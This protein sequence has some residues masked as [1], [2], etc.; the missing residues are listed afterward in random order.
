VAKK[1][2]SFKFFGLF[3]VPNRK[4]QG[5]EKLLALLANVYLIY[6]LLP[7]PLAVLNY[8]SM[9]FEQFFERL[10]GSLIAVYLMVVFILFAVTPFLKTVL[11]N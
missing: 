8:S 3:V 5:G 10:L 2:K 1:K 9:N 6:K 4:L 7:L 11:E